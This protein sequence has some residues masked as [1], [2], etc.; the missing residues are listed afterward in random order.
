MQA[1]RLRPMTL[2]LVDDNPRFLRILERFLDGLGGEEISVIGTAAG[3]QEALAKARALR[4]DVIL[5]DLAM[6]DTH[7]L[8]VIPRLRR[9]L[10]EVGI[11]ALT[12]LNPE[13]YREAALGAGA[14]GF[15]TKAS[16]DAD[17][18]PAIRRLTETRRV[19]RSPKGSAG[20]GGSAGASGGPDG[21]HD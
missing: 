18:L 11:I 14:D 10:P 7:G 1:R 17:L 12:L 16:L 9:I 6:P 19:A 8:D 5:L 4:P 21:T 3:G 2:L 13:S 15:V 20:R